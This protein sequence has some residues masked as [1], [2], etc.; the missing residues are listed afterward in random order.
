MSDQVEVLKLVA[1][2]LDAA[3]IPYMLSG[4]VA[5]N[6]HAQPR[7]TRDID[8]V[9]EL[10]IRDAPRIQEMFAEDFYV[11]EDDVRDS[12][13]VRGLFNIIHNATVVKVDFIV[14]KD[15]AYR[16]EEFARRSPIDLEGVPIS[17]VSPE[18]LIL[19]KLCWGKDS[20]SEMQLRDVQNLLASPHEL[21]WA[22]L[23]RWAGELGVA[24]QLDQA[25]KT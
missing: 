16:Q 3:G 11:D 7:M 17:V 5:M 22:Y 25:R 4:S 6:F 2:K 15:E 23:A 9:L 1:R 8:I 10:S 20:R 12:I 14:R 19:S 18:D 13:K 21:D 24:D